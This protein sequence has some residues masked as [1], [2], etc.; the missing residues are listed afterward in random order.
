MVEDLDLGA[1]TTVVVRHWKW[2]VGLA[3]S[4]M[5][6]A[7]LLSWFVLTLKYSAAATVVTTAPRYQPALSSAIEYAPDVKVPAKAYTGLAKNAEVMRRVI[8]GMGESLPQGLRSPDA[9][10]GLCTVSTIGDL[11]GIRLSLRHNDAALAAEIANEWARLY[12]EQFREIYG[13]LGDDLY[14]LEEQVLGAQQTLEQPRPH[15]LS[16]RVAIQSPC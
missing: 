14:A 8:S 7:S 16:F 15:L 13:P 9:L 5:V 3:V 2:V 6:L 4:G 10:A 1:Y 11:T 12:V